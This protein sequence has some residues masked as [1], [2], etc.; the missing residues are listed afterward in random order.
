MANP[1]PPKDSGKTPST[2]PKPTGTTSS[3]TKPTSST[4]PAKTGTPTK[5]PASTSPP[6]KTPASDST[7]SIKPTAKTVQPKKAKEKKWAAESGS[8]KLGQILVDLG[9][10]DDVLLESVLE[11]A[12]TQDTTLE[13]VALERGL[14]NEDQLIQAKAEQSG[15]KL[16]N[17]DEI[18]PQPV[19]INLVQEVMAVQY[20]MLPLSYEND[21][22][23]VA[24]SDP[25]NLQATDDLR[26]LLGIKQVN[27]VMAPLV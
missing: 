2:P 16:V 26:N 17:L 9:F 11:D 7:S 13:Q 21:I 25:N 14:I 1:T 5:T 4:P 27:A 23:T 10:L 19:A 3:S 18:K 15:M 24:M 12:R 22:L 6:T 8:K 20:K